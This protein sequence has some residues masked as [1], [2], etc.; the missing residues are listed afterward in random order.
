MCFTNHCWHTDNHMHGSD[1]KPMN[2]E[3]KWAKTFGQQ[4]GYVIFILYASN[5]KSSHVPGASR[6]QSTFDE[7]NSSTVTPSSTSMPGPDARTT[8][9]GLASLLEVVVIIDS[10]S[11]VW[12]DVFIPLRSNN[13]LDAFFIAYPLSINLLTLP[14]TMLVTITQQ[15]GMRDDITDW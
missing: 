8:C 11:S 3:S 1:G 2:S 6:K 5:P 9:L 13:I 4:M 14:S 12:I 15:S 10:N 7:R